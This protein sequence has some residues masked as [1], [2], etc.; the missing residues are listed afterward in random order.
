MTKLNQISGIFIFL[1][2]VLTLY[3]YFFNPSFLFVASLF[4][5]FAFLIFFRSLKS[6]KLLLSL[7]ILGILCLAFCYANGYF[8][9]FKKLFSVNQ[10]LLALLSSV[11]FLR[12]I[13]TPKTTKNT[14]LPSGKGAFLKTYFGVHLFGAV[15]NLSSLIIVADKLYQKRKLTTT[16][17][18][19]LTRS[20]ATDA[21]WS[22][23]FVAFGATLTYAPKLD[24]FVVVLNGLILALVGFLLTCKEFLG[25]EEIKSFQ[26]YPLSFHTLYIPFLLAF[27]VMSTHYFYKNIQIIILICSYSLLL[28]IAILLLQRGI[29]GFFEAFYLHVKEELP[30]MRAE[31][32]LFLVAGFFGISASFLLLGLHV[33]LPF[34]VFN[35]QIASLFLAL[36]IALG[37]IGIHP[38]ITIAILGEFLQNANNTL[39]GAA[40]LMAWAINVSAS[41]FSGLNLTISARY[42][43]D[44]MSILRL[45]AKYTFFMFCICVFSLYFLDLIWI[46]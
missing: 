46:K 6:K 25:K 8:V 36:C 44:T 4:F 23:F 27:L 1:S 37:T 29:K 22:P 26:G 15:I 13:A 28:S 12:L 24:F 33:K 10:Y 41:P 42:G 17:V 18:S 9:D 31:I 39:L 30:K 38:I 32:S 40:F 14:K 21:F 35:W 11:G 3:S 2:L 34:E 20:F 45:N 43:V 16:Q 5:W 7:F 19:L